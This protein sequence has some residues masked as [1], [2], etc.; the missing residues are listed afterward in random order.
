MDTI[1][2]VHGKHVAGGRRATRRIEAPQEEPKEHGRRSGKHARP[3]LP[4]VPPAVGLHTPKEHVEFSP[5]SST[6]EQRRW[7]QE[8]WALPSYQRGEEPIIIRSLE[9]PANTGP[10]DLFLH[11][12]P[13]PVITGVEKERKKLNTGGIALAVAVTT[14]SLLIAGGHISEA[15]SA[16]RTGV[17][18]NTGKTAVTPPIIVP[19]ANI[20]HSIVEIGVRPAPVAPAPPAP[21]QAAPP[22]P[23]PPAPAPPATH[24]V[25]QPG[26][27]VG[28]IAARHGVNMHQMLA[29]NGLG[30]HTIIYPGQRLVLA[31]PAKAVAQPATPAPAPAP[32]PKQAAP[33]PAP[34]PAPMSATTSGKGAAVA[35]AALRQVGVRQDCVM[36]VGRALSSALG[37]SVDSWRKWPHE[38]YQFG[39]AVASPLPGDLIYYVHGS[40]AGSLAHIAI[41]IGDGKAVHGGWNGNDTIIFGVNVGSGPNYIRLR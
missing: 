2:R 11:T 33:A 41:Y 10:L 15:N 23:P 21:A 22:P 14:G 12:D 16:T 4:P 34:A 7:L 30:L 1:E 6:P 40:G 36:A 9:D 19:D 38:Y 26:D 8:Q 13:I 35:Q 5:I 28:K 32:A 37:G 17:T 39:Y 3:P 29:A 31:G 18:S 24:A 27:T 25:V 20:K